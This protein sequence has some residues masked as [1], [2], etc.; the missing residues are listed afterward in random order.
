M[1]LICIKEVDSGYVP[2]THYNIGD[3]VYANFRGGDKYFDSKTKSELFMECFFSI[4]EHRN[5]IIDN[6]LDGES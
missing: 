6:I 4:T 3:I 1:K 2:V 5:S